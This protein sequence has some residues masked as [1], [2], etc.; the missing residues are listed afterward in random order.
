[1][2]EMPGWKTPVLGQDTNPEGWVDN[3]RRIDIR[4]NLNAMREHIGKDDSILDVGCYAGYLNDYF[5]RER[6]TG[7]DLFPEHIELAQKLHPGQEHKYRVGDLFELQ[8]RANV[9]ICS[10]VL[11]HIP[12]FEKAV[13]RLIKCTERLLICV[14]KITPEPG[15]ERHEKNGQMFYQRSFSQQ[16]VDAA[17]GKCKVSHHRKYSNV[18]KWV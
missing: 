13:E 11:I 18:Y 15:I 9:V 10:R 6:Y 5:G 4:H 17:F 3:P 12:Y 2:D 14:L 16:M 1:M 7:I 8:D